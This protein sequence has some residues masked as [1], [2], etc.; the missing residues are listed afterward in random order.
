MKY[1]S[2]VFKESWSKKKRNTRKMNRA[3]GERVSVFLL[4]KVYWGITGNACEISLVLFCFFSVAAQ[5]C[6]QQA[7][8]VLLPAGPI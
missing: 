5:Q 3:Q 8:P 4:H 1:L 2:V 6:R 7:T